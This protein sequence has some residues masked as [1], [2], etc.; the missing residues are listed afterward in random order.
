MTGSHPQGL[1][2]VLGFFVVVLFFFFSSN[3]ESDATETG[4]GWCGTWRKFINRDLKAGLHRTNFT[5]KGLLTHKEGSVIA[6]Y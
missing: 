4:K 5:G 2:C 6:S 1:C 3:R